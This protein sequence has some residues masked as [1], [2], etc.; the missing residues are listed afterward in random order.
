MEVVGEFDMAVISFATDYG[1]PAGIPVR[2]FRSEGGK[3]LLER[4]NGIIFD[5]KPGQ[6]ACLL[7]H[8][9]NEFVKD[10]KYIRFKGHI[11]RVC[12]RE[13]EFTS[14]GKYTFKQGGVINTIKFI[15]NGK[16]RAKRNLKKYYGGNLR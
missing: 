1:Y 5:V 12:S 16:R 7:M 11:S 2:K 4:P 13:M 15:W 10:I 3:F 6:R 8:T 14:E 9:H